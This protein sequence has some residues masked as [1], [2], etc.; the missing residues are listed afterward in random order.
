VFLGAAIGD[1]GARFSAA[2]RQHRL[3]RSAGI[4]S[5]LHLYA[6]GD[7]LPRAMLRDLDHWLLDWP[8][9]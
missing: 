8:R 6:D 2:E 4:A 7:G 9:P 3:L 1:S 5:E